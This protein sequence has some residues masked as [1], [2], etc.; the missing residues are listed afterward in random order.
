MKKL[1]NAHVKESENKFLDLS[2]T[3]PPSKFC[4]NSFVSFCVIILLTNQPTNQPA[5]TGENIT[6]WFKKPRVKK[7]NKQKSC[8]ENYFHKVQL[9]MW[10]HKIT[11][12]NSYI[13]LLVSQY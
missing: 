8:P 1:K 2:E 12:S 3:R 11:W 10:F 13:Y 6:S 7:N 9:Q 5:G 4:G